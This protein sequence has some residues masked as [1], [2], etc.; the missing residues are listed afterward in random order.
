MAIMNVTYRVEFLALLFAYYSII[1]GAPKQIIEVD[2]ALWQWGGHVTYRILA[3][4][5]HHSSGSYD[6]ESD[7][8]SIPLI[9]PPN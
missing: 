5:I 6:C 4:S 2:P 7:P 3:P 1:A 8:T 9:N